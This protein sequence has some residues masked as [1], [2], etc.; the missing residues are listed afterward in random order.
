MAY[1]DIPNVSR[2]HP[3]GKRNDK[4]IQKYEVK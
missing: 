1:D 2:M 4:I 3:E